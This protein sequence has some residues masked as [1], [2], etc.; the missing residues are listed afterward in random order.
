MTPLTTGMTAPDHRA[1][2][3]GYALLCVLLLAGPAAVALFIR[4]QPASADTSLVVRPTAE[5]AVARHARPNTVKTVLLSDSYLLNLQLTGNRT[6]L[7]GAISVRLFNGGG[8][9]DGARI[10]VTYTSLEMKMAPIARVL[11]QTGR[12]LYARPGPEL[13]MSG[14]WRLRFS[15][16]PADDQ[17]FEV[18]A[19]DRV[20]L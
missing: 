5:R 2:R 15:V 10:V 17:P 14:R 12:G 4:L 11:P 13:S 19:V 18:S 9:V 3:V 1:A 16:S 7:P 6:S 8:P 20:A